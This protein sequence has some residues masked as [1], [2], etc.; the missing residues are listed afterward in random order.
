MNKADTHKNTLLQFTQGNA[1]TKN[2]NRVFLS[3]TQKK[4]KNKKFPPLQKNK[5][6]QPHSPQQTTIMTIYNLTPTDRATTDRRRAACNSTL[7]IG[8][9][10]SSLDSFEVVESSVLRITFCAEMPAHRQSA[11]RYRAF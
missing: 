7:A 9:V 6:A 10:S 5:T 1:T 8:G 4:L 2:C 11:N 3:S